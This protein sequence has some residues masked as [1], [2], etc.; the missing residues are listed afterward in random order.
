LGSRREDVRT[1]VELRAPGEG[2]TYGGTVKCRLRYA[3]VLGRAS[4][5]RCSLTNAVVALTAVERG[6]DVA[7]ALNSCLGPEVARLALALFGR[8]AQPIAAIHSGHSSPTSPCFGPPFGLRSTAPPHFLFLLVLSLSDFFP[9]LSTR[10]AP[11]ATPLHLLPSSSSSTPLL[12]LRPPSPAS[13]SF[14]CPSFRQN[15]LACWLLMPGAQVRIPLSMDIFLP[16]SKRSA[17]LRRY[18]SAIKMPAV[19]FS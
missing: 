13:S 7:C 4:E 11:C 15:W 1:R 17:S 9:S 6:V 3:T 2:L 5:L 14:C 16:L 18:C 12:R 10:P 8:C 19:E